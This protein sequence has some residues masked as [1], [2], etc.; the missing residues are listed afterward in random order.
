MWELDHNEGWEAKTWCFWIVVLEKTLESP[1]D[2]KEIQP[3]HPKGNQSWIFIGK[4]DAEIETP[5]L[6]PTDVKNWLIGK[7]TDAGQDWSRR[8][9]WQR[10]RWLDGVTDWMDMS[11][12]KP[13]EMV[14]D[15]KACQAVVHRVA[16]NRTWL[17]DWTAVNIF[18]PYLFGT[19]NYIR[20]W[21]CKEW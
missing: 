14:M 10:M 13:W 7:D 15:R 19:C 18:T 9:G 8:R 5:T 11:L 2:R 6:S 17:G 16:K 1:L 20:C 4:T 12:R 3:V 21:S